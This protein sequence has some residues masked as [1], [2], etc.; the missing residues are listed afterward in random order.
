MQILGMLGLIF[1]KGNLEQ[2]IE[3]KDWEF[4]SLMGELVG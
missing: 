3:L 4:I 1:L 2:M